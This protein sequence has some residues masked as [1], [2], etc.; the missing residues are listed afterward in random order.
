MQPTVQ[1]SAGE[2][3]Y[4]IAPSDQLRKWWCANCRNF[5][6]FSHHKLITVAEEGPMDF[7][8]API[9]IICDKCRW[10]IHIQTIV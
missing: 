9:T 7:L 8:T 1:P 6:F 4:H 10:Q 5:L 2:L 3:T